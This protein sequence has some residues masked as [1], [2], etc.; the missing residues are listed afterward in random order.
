MADKRLIADLTV[1]ELED[2]ITKRRHGEHQRQWPNDE[3][4]LAVPLPTEVAPPPTPEPEVPAPI[5]SDVPAVPDYTPAHY[6]EGAP[7]FEDD[8]IIEGHV[9]RELA[10]RE[11]KAVNRVL[12][13][14]EV[15]ALFGII[16]IVMIGALGLTEVDDNITRTDDLNATA[17]AAQVVNRVQPTATPLISVRQVVLPGGHIW[18]ADNEHQFNYSE[19]P[20]PYREAFRNQH[21]TLAQSAAPAIALPND[22]I[23]IQIPAIG[24]DNTVRTGDDWIS[25]QAGVGH[26]PFSGRPGGTG[27]MVLTAHNDI[28]GEIFRDLEKLV[29]GDE[30]RVQSQDGQWYTYVVRESI[31]VEPSEVWVLDQNLGAQTPIA[32]LITCHPYRV[33]THRKIVFAELV[34]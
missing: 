13:L 5:E 21:Q 20:G 28:F 16:A 25:L 7:R 10:P 26:H 29:P 9:Q 1:E 11:P 33:D 8:I 23:R 3:R 22:P 2:I 14:V 18:S 30:I 34:N 24:V 4:R 31:V 32:T 19:V 15:G 6:T 17:E 27:N 12:L